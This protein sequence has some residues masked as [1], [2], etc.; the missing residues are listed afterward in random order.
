M[1]E[2]DDSR[3]DTQA[4]GERVVV[5]RS[6]I[7]DLHKRIF[8]DDSVSSVSLEASRIG[9]DKTWR[10]LLPSFSAMKALDDVNLEHVFMR[11]PHESL[12]EKGTIFLIQTYFSNDI[13]ETSASVNFS[14]LADRSRVITSADLK[15]GINIE[16]VDEEQNDLREAMRLQML[17]EVLSAILSKMFA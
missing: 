14:Y 6:E 11:K 9:L 3:M 7:D 12:E 8:S 17:K 5:L 10:D 2:H 1:N 16:R 13:T 4:L 15:P